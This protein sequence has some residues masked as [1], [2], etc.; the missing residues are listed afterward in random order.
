MPVVAAVVVVV[1]WVGPRFAIVVGLL[2]GGALLAAVG[3]VGGLLFILFFLI[4]ERLV[5]LAP[6]DIPL[7][8]SHQNVRRNVDRVGLTG[9]THT[10]D[11]NLLSSEVLAFLE[12]APPSSG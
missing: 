8:A 7:P 11:L 10:R 6:L 5:Q 12:R 2:C 1:G 3:V 9:E 4:V